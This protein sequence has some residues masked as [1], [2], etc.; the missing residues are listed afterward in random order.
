MA[1]SVTITLLAGC[2]SAPQA[3]TDLLRIDNAITT[4]PNDARDYSHLVLANGLKVLL[5]SDSQADK[6]AASLSVYRG[7]FDDPKA[8]PGLAHFLEHMLFI[9]TEKYP[10]PDAYFSFVESHSG[11]SNAYTAPEVTTYFFDVKPDAF[12]EGLDRLT[13]ERRIS[14]LSAAPQTPARPCGPE[15]S[16]IIDHGDQDLV[17]G[18]DLGR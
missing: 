14:A 1:V 11:S 5:I 12:R 13:G 8:R 17:I 16:L 15:I 18:D 7:S 9:G 6:S 2:A 4:S 10:E 3:P